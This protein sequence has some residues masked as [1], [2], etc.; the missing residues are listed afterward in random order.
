M[1]VD[2]DKVFQDN[3]KLWAKTCPK[4]ALMLTYIDSTTIEGCLTKKG[5]DNLKIFIDDQK[6]ALHSQE[7]A[8]EEARQWVE[9]LPL[10][11]IALVCVYGIGLGYYYDA[12]YS[13]LKKNR[14]RRVV[15]LEDDLAVIQK[16]LETKRASKILQDPQV[17]LLYFKDLK[18]D[19]TIFE[20]LYWNFAMTRLAVSALASYSKNK[21]TS[22]ELL[23][24]KIAYDAAMKNAL[25]DEYMRYG[26]SFYLNFYQN[27]LWLDRSYLGNH[28]FGK[29]HKVP[30]IICGAGPSLAKNLPLVKQLLDKAVV[31]A[32]GSALNVLN[33]ADFQ[34]HFGA[35]IDPNPAQYTRLSQN[36][37]YE[38]P[39][40]YRNRMYHHAFKMIHGPRLYI[41][42]SGG[43]D[44]AEL[45]EKKLGI[46]GGEELDEGHN[47]VNFCVEVAHAMGCDPIIFVGMD[48]AFTDMLEYAPGVV[49]NAEVC[50]STILDVEDQDSK[51]ILRKDI[52]GQ[53]TYT[54]WKWIAEADWIADFA[55]DHPL[56]TL[57]NCTEGGLGFPGIAN[58]SLK[59]TSEKLLCRSYEISN[60]IHGETQN[61]AIA[62]IKV[63]KIVK[64]MNE[65]SASLKRTLESL[66]ILF[67]ETQTH[68]A[69][70]KAGQLD[71]IQSGKA[72]LAETE[73]AEEIGYKSVVGVFNEVFTRLLSGELHEIHVRR[74]S[75]K[76]RQLKKL[77]LSCR[78]LAFLSDVVKVNDG[79]LAYAL[80][81]RKKQKK[82]KIVSIELPPAQVVAQYEFSHHK[83]IISDPECDLFVDEIFDPVLV[84]DSREDGKVLLDGHILRVFFDHSWKLYECYVE[85]N[86]LL[87]GQAVLFYPDGNLKAESFYREGK[88]H[89]PS[90]FWNREGKL[91]AESFFIQGLQQ[92]KGFFYYPSGKLYS[93]KRYK[94][95]LWHGQQE[96][97]YENGMLKT[98]MHYGHGQLLKEAL[99]LLPDGSLDRPIYCY[100]TFNS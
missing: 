80:D 18:A 57:I 51:A 26:A 53:P 52:Y 11:G 21:S 24:H 41:T 60:R 85:K 45:F 86:G 13:W 10:K 66:T 77:E 38:V 8:I 97:Y 83:M 49:E 93:L 79:L 72:A 75:R 4:Q 69:K 92:G 74:Y 50:R 28:F 58:Q 54:L 2:S 3:L 84:P 73:L 76:Q 55:T 78:K 22:I 32:G 100:S 14:K 65:L 99:L 17:Q 63:Q 90:R 19:E 30:A 48:L 96:Y 98:L 46:E 68:I 33:G 94:N 56:I 59:E 95:G 88:L 87:D 7:G 91:L 47:V 71:V 81:E 70:I 23:R 5:E 16:L 67:Q 40:F 39:F 25:V 37:G 34:P 1:P 89:G 44:T 29:F 9:A 62:H 61:S 64:I 20:S 36:S 42:G 35:G 27:M 43:Y 82:G 15:F 12:I 6:I 31:F